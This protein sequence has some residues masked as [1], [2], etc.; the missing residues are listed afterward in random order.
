MEVRIMNKKGT[1]RPRFWDS[2]KRS[3]YRIG[4][5]RKYVVL[6]LVVQSLAWHSLRYVKRETIGMAG[7]FILG[8]ESSKSK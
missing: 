6:Y 8:Y 3:D 4:K 7:N 1:F 2:G 5:G